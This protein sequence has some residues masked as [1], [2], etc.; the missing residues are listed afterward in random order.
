MSANPQIEIEA[1]EALLDIGVSLPFFKIPFTRKVVRLTMKRP[2]LGGQIRLARLYLRTGITYEEML[3]F[4]KHEELAYMAVHG[5]RVSKMVALTI[6]RGAFSTWL[7]SDLLAWLL[8]WFV[9]DEY[10]RAAS[11]QFL[12]L[13]GTKSF[14]TIIK[15]ISTT[16]PMRPRLSQRKSEKGS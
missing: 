4:S 3:E 9:D 1:A 6:C 2:C 16:N 7:F 5:R 12:C 15:S 13:L 11:M 8:R 14:M 10:L